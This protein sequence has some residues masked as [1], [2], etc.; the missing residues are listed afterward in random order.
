MSETA[1]H[2]VENLI[3]RVP[4]RQ[5]VISFPKRI[6][7]Y[8]QTHEILQEVLQVVVNEIRKR[9]I[10]CSPSITNAQFG[11]VTFIQRFG[12]TLNLHPHFHLIVADGVFE[13]DATTAGLLSS[14]F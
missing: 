1:A 10:A 5:W 3:P 8:L 12:S 4:C 6:R 2:L 11:A 13:K 9:V 7:Y 14:A